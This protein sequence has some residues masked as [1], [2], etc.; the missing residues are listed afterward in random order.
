MDPIELALKDLKLQNTKNISAV[1]KLHGV[2]RSTLSRR[3]N[4]VTNPAKMQHEKQQLL[5]PQ[6]EKELIEYI[7]MLTKRGTLPTTA[8]VRN[9]AG[10]IAGKL[11]GR[12]WSQRFCM[13]HQDALLSRY[14]KNIDIQR[15]KAEN[16]K[17]LQA[18]Y[19]VL[20]Q[21][22]KEYDILPQNTYNMDE[23]GFMIGVSTKQHR[24]FSKQAFQKGQILA[25]IQDGNRQWI[26]V[27][28]TI[29]ADGSWLPPGV[30]FAGNIRDTWVKDKVMD[31]FEGHIGSTTNGWTDDKMGL[32]WLQQIFDRYSKPK[33][34]N[35]RDW[36]LLF[37]DGHG[38]HLNMEFIKWCDKHYI[39][40][41]IYPPHSTHRLQP[42]DVSLFSPLATFYGQELDGYIH[43]T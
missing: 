41:A 35:G 7:N 25:N 6:Q 16:P 18:F 10:D 1:A 27:I 40:L 33:A 4:G 31:T 23:K 8:I 30:I 29:C 36:R 12:C 9:F 5:S 42:L 19:D 37:S 28:A 21:K 2:D 34:R 20:E 24:I 38:S 11:P 14:L 15:Q 32:Y 3:F 26:T 43:E 13:R 22:T 17:A 39:L